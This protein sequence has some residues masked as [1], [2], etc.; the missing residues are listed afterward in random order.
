[1][2]ISGEALPLT[3]TPFLANT[4]TLPALRDQIRSEDQIAA[5]PPPPTT[6]LPALGLI[7]PHSVRSSSTEGRSLLLVPSVGGF[8]GPGDFVR[9][10]PQFP[11]DRWRAE[12]DQVN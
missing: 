11:K 8:Q 7:T 6:H 1:M 9:V 3:A 12:A 5:P 2:E 4:W 10:A